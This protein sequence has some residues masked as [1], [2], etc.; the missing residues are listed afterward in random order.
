MELE[1]NE[2]LWVGKIEYFA[3][4]N[5]LRTFALNIFKTITFALK[6]ITCNFWAMN[7]GKSVASIRIDASMMDQL[8][9]D[10]RDENRSLSNYLETLLYRM[11]YRPMNEDT[12]EAYRESLRGEMAGVVDTSSTEAMLASILGDE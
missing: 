10:A 4:N 1:Q 3:P 9:A 12:I 2:T 5:I 11:G 7:E 8:R 6:R